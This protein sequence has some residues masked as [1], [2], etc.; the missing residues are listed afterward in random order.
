MEK[1]FIKF[2]EADR[3]AFVAK[4]ADVAFKKEIE[5]IK[6]TADSVAGTFKVIIS[7]E[8]RD[9]QG[10]IVSMSGW[11]LAFYKMNPTV[12]WAHDYWG[13]PIAMCTNIYIT[14]INGKS[15]LVAEGKFAPTDQGQEIR[16][17]YDGGFL[18]ATSVGF[19]PKEF[20]DDGGTITKQELL[21]FSFVPVPANPYAVALSFDEMK[22]LGINV[23]L[24]ATKSMEFAF[25]TSTVK[26]AIIKADQLGDTCQLDD[27]TPGILAEDPKNPKGPLV[28][29]PTESKTAKPDGDDDDD[30]N[31]PQD[32]PPEHKELVKTLKKGLVSEHKRH[33]GVVNKNVDDFMEKMGELAGQAD[34]KAFMTKSSDDLRTKMDAENGEHKKSMKALVKCYTDGLTKLLTDDGNNDGKS[35]MKGASKE[36]LAGLVKTITE[37]IVACEIALKGDEGENHAD[38][39]NADELSEEEKAKA[40]A[41]KGAPKSGSKNGKDDLN[42]YLVAKNIIRSLHEAT[43]KAIEHYNKRG[44]EIARGR[45]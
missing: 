24:L 23:H 10:E 3:D 26:D 30:D 18:K 38:G 22:E 7:T 29:V 34:G 15:C 19:I 16:K 20:S 14:E 25:K 39:E 33:T 8:D 36:K 28:C 32:M 27:G 31:D 1:S 37:A 35:V 41:L 12:L 5:T 9:R 2:S 40:E 43:T 44:K 13:Q 11:D 42:E 45:K 21:E 17:L 4:C 6:A